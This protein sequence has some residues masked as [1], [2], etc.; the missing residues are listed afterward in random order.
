MFPTFQAKIE[1]KHSGPNGSKSYP[2]L[3]CC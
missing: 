3:V 1:E 2:N